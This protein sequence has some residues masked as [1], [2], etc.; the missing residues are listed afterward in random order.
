MTKELKDE[1]G[2]RVH[3]YIPELCEQL[4]QKKIDR[5]DFLRTATLL[6]ISAGAAYAM[7]G[8]ITGQE[9][10]VPTAVAATPK[11]GGTLKFSMQIQEMTDPATFDWT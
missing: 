9:A 4:R 7:A 10:I 5:R 1:S 2:K 6:G 3:S 8:K 11:K